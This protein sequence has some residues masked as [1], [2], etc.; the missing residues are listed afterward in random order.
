MS[1]N[2]YAD[3]NKEENKNYP[4]HTQERIILF[5]TKVRAMLRNGE[6]P[7]REFSRPGVANVLILRYENGITRKIKDRHRR[8]SKF[9]NYNNFVYDHLCAT[10]LGAYFLLVVKP[11]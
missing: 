4:H 8:P 11:I 3:K 6:A 9:G 10:I 1:I 2:L 7:P 5:G